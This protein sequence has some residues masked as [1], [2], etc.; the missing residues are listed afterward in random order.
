MVGAAKERGLARKMAGIAKER[1]CARK[2]AGT[3]KERGLA[4]KMAEGEEGPREN[5]DEPEK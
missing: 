2:M 5:G 1:G 4:R 3:A